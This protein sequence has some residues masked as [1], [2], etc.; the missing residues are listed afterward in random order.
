MRLRDFVHVEFA[1]A[2]QEEQGAARVDPE[3]V[4]TTR[5]DPALPPESDGPGRLAL[6]ARTL[7]RLRLDEGEGEHAVTALT[8]A[9]SAATALVPLLGAFAGAAMLQVSLPP[10][11]VRPVNLL[12]LLAEGVLLP[13]AFLLWTLVLSR[14]LGRSTGS[15][16][17]VALALGWI[18]G[19]AMGSGV[20]RLA[21]RVL[22]RSGVAAQ[23]FTGYSH[24]FWIGTLVV[25]VGLGFWRFAFA[26]YVFAWSSTLP[27]TA[28]GVHAL[29]TGLTFPV[30][31]LPGVDAPSAEQIRVSEFGSLSSSGG[32]GGG[33][34]GSTGDLLADQALRKAW[35]SATLAIVAFWGLLPRLV[36]IV[37]ARLAVRRGV[38]KALLDPTSLL[39]LD[40]L[41][42]PASV[43]PGGPEQGPRVE[44]EPSS[45][46]P[47]APLEQR[48]GR[49]L[50]VVVFAAEPP[51]AASLERT[52]LVRLGL[53]GRTHV[54]ASDD[55]DDAMEAVIAALAGPDAPEG[56]VTVFA[57][58]AIPDDL[59]EEF[60]SGVV[61][62]LGAGAPVH[63]LLT[64]VRRFRTSGRGRSLDARLAAWTELA[65]RTGVPADRVHLEE[66]LG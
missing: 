58:G 40:A 16:H 45:A 21:G 22:R 42:P 4:A 37:V 61:A 18:R 15:L 1:R 57:M 48:A 38:R 52:R 49:G 63:V 54:I 20:G 65:G 28:D 7:L 30:D 8:G 64:G 3:A 55:D 43:P 25:F 17:W 31:W 23:L 60:L 66:D 39:I 34:V 6:Y 13:G 56:A 50:D 41:A 11:D 33:Y 12:H 29:F 59:K 5:A 2:W 44:S 36:G 47:V 35:W 10:N 51:T 53:S 19:R 24:S 27:V 14:L 26:D 46:V 9:L 62:A 32:S